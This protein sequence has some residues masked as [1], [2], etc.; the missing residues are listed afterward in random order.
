MLRELFAAPILV[1]NVATELREAI[2]SVVLENIDVDLETPSGEFLHTSFFTEPNFIGRH[3]PMLADE[4]LSCGR[5]L[6]RALRVREPQQISQSWLNAFTFGQ[7]ERPHHHLAPSVVLSGC[8]YVRTPE[9]GGSLYFQ[10]PIRER[11]AHQ[12]FFAD[13]G[14]RQAVEIEH[15]AGQLILFPSWLYHGVSAN[16]SGEQRVSIAFNLSA[17][18]SAR[19]GRICLEFAG[20]LPMHNLTP[21]V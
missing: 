21:P 14:G 18:A 20:E 16:Q 7:Q 1:R 10:D 4:I 17:D 19:S 11:V 6:A 8:Y 2:E 5:E 3:L 13:D 12:A 15:R 9:G